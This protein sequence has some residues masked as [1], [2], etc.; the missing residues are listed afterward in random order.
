MGDCSLEAQKFVAALLTVDPA[1][2]MTAQKARAH[3]GKV[4]CDTAE[5]YN[6]AASTAVGRSS[7]ASSGSQDD[8]SN[9]FPSSQP[10]A[11][12]REKKS[13][14]QALPTFRLGAGRVGAA[15]TAVRKL[16]SKRA[17]VRVS[18]EVDL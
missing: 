14:W 17:S 8:F 2:R 9:L 5:S 7:T 12:K 3:R 15:L 4:R 16:R 13:I 11:P 6:S 18:V 1:N 10:S